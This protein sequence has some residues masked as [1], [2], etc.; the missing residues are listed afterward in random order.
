MPLIPALAYSLLSIAFL[1]NDAKPSKYVADNYTLWLSDTSI[2]MQ[3]NRGG[4]VTMQFPSSRRRL[5][6]DGPQVVYPSVF[7]KID[8]VIYRNQDRFEYDWKVAPR[9]DPSAIK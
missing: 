6:R 2:A 1:A 3:P 8:L 5:S 7:S 9:A 4:M